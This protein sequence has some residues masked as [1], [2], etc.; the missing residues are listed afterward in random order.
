M[1][2]STK[3]ISL[4]NLKWE[5]VLDEEAT[6][7]LP[8]PKS[9]QTWDE[10]FAEKYSDAPTAINDDYSPDIPD[11]HYIPE[12][13]WP[14]G[15]IR[16]EKPPFE[17]PMYQKTYED[18]CKE[19]DE[20]IA[21]EA[22]AAEFPPPPQKKPRLHLYTKELVLCERDEDTQEEENEDWDLPTD[23]LLTPK[24]EGKTLPDYPESPDAVENS[25]VENHD[26]NSPEDFQNWDDS[27]DQDWD[28]S[29][30]SEYKIFN[31]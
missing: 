1:E 28:L 19:W 10:Y 26:H 29:R 6:Q 15:S 2:D 13:L 18:I 12:W 7:P 9:E 8:S 4:S 25:V 16:A 14:D 3:P 5:D 27:S 22:A 23:L 24:T 31:E 30:I 21:A 17:I 20:E 11:S